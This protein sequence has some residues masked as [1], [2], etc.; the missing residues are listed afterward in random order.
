MSQENIRLS[1]RDIFHMLDNKHCVFVMFADR[2]MKQC[3]AALSRDDLPREVREM[4]DDHIESLKMLGRT[5]HQC[6]TLLNETKSVIY[7]NL[8]ADENFFDGDALKKKLDEPGPH[9][10]KIGEDRKNAT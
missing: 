2:L 6:D 10:K 5:G 4:L 1:I 7:G 8:N 9:F 3:N